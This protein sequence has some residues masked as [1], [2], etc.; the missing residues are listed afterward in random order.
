MTKQDERKQR[1][2][3]FD[4]LDEAT[5]E[6]RRFKDALDRLPDAPRTEILG[7][8]PGHPDFESLIALFDRALE[9]ERKQQ[10]N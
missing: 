8:M 7:L 4:C 2:R 6:L 10:L 1:T 3:A 9:A 5:A